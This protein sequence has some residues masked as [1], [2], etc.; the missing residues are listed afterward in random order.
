MNQIVR[1]AARWRAVF[2][3]PGDKSMSHRALLFGAL[4]DGPSTVTHLAPGKDV[5]S[6]A[7]CLED[8]GVRIERAG[9]ET[10]VVHGKGPSGLAAPVR[11]LDAGNSGTTIRLLTG[12]L[13]SRPFTSVV[14]G[15]GSLRRRPMRRIVEPLERMGAR[16]ETSAGGTAPLTIRGSRLRAADLVLPVASAQLKSCILLAGLLA[17][18][19][20]SVTEP[21]LS[22]DHTERMLSGMGVRIRRDGLRLEIEGPQ[23]PSPSDFDVPGDISSAAFPL[24]AAALIPDSELLIENVGVNPTR[25][26]VLEVLRGMGC[27]IEELNPRTLH[28]E[29]RADL[30]I[31]TASLRG[32]EIAGDMIPKVIDEI[33]VLA[34][35]ASQ[36]SGRT[37]VRDAG[38]L[39]VKETDRIAAIVKNLAAMGVRAETFEDG[40]AVEGPQRLRGAVIDSMEDH[41][42]AMAFAVAGLLAE[43]R[44]R[45]EGT[46]CADISYPGFF[47]LLSG[48][49]HV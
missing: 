21:A 15:D 39:R 11:P 32:T 29:P 3:V 1:Q 13:A 47:G 44:T 36:A 38:E 8:L 40:F 27:P 14:T 31:R 37:V 26:G 33:P 9:R 22:R 4:A 46:E 7:S 48:I 35:A 34:V 23:T 24:V 28:G 45:I 30:R 42:I 41:R 2:R 20:T 6:T 18:G 12:I 5:A 49:E 43:G 25:T 10:A 16:I 19:R 17:E